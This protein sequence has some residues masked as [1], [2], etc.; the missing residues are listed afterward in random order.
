M[1]S[2]FKIIYN[3]NIWYFQL[4]GK[5]MSHWNIPEM[6]EEMMAWCFFSWA[7][8][9][10]LLA[11]NY[12]WSYSRKTWSWSLRLCYNPSPRSSLNWEAS[13]WWT[14]PTAQCCMGY[15][16]QLKPTY[17]LHSKHIHWAMWMDFFADLLKILLSVFSICCVCQCC[18]L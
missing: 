5:V 11:Y 16:I 1:Y 14:H 10:I 18:Q 4:N 6:G 2:V 12:L 17:Q 13:L 7:M 15:Y 9:T 8:S 3:N